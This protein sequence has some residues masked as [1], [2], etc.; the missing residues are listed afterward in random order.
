MTWPCRRWPCCDPSARP[1]A[2]KLLR[3]LNTAACD[4]DSVGGLLGGGGK[5]HACTLPVRVLVGPPVA[6]MRYVSQPAGDHRQLP[7]S[8]MTAMQV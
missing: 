2:Y 5:M 6:T 8:E 7:R 1:P 3:V 4:S